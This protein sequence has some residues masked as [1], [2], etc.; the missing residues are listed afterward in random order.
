MFYLSFYP[1][2]TKALPSA[3][4]HNRDSESLV[5]E[6]IVTHEMAREEY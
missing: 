2:H 1:P 6:T 3:L 5:G 4:K